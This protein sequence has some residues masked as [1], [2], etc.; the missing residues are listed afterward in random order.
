MKFFIILSILIVNVNPVFAGEPGV[1]RLDSTFVARFVGQHREFRPIE[2]KLQDYYRKRDWNVVWFA[3]NQPIDQASLFL[4][5]LEN[6]DNY[7]LSFREHHLSDTLSFIAQSFGGKTVPKPLVKFVD[8]SLSALYFKYYPDFWTGVLD[9]KAEDEIEW[10]ILQPD[11]SYAQ[12]L[13]SLLSGDIRRNPFI[14]YRKFHQ[15]FFELQKVLV[16]YKEIKNSGGWGTI[17]TEYLTRGDSGIFVQQLIRRLKTTGDLR[18]EHIPDKYNHDVEQAVRRFQQRHG[19]TED[20]I[21]G[22]KTLS[23]MNASVDIRIDQI[24]LNMERWRWVPPLT[25]KKYVSVNIPEFKLYLYDDGDVQMTMP[26]IVGKSGAETVVFKDRIKYIVVNPYWNIPKS[27][28]VEE[29][30]PKAQRDSNYFRDRKIEIGIDGDYDV[31]A[32][33]T[34]N[35][36]NYSAESFPFTLRQTPGRHNQLG[37]IKFI[38]PNRY[39]IYLHDT[40]ARRLFDKRKRSLSHGCVRVEQP[41]ELADMLLTQNKNYTGRKLQ[42]MVGDEEKMDTW[43]TLSDPVPVYILYFTVWAEGGV[44]NFREDIYGHDD[45]LRTKL[46]GI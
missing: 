4:N 45:A 18:E 16:R 33:D 6:L 34:I 41:Y 26:V 10:N 29:M 24:L 13:D 12:L 44:A 3:G 7:G 38:F 37:T 1:V 31:V 8:V 46:T 2:K 28:A 9:P 11:V 21:T 30:L 40:P 35:W 20:G 22:E 36:Q 17:E 32:E 43:I 39:A 5:V 25:E 14:D 27:I 42:K 19:L 23:A 15:G